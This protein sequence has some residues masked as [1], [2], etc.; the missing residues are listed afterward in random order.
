MEGVKLQPPAG[1]VRPAT[2]TWALQTLYS[3]SAQDMTP[4]ATRSGLI[5]A[6]EATST[7]MRATEKENRSSCKAYFSKAGAH[8]AYVRDEHCC[9]SPPPGTIAA[10]ALLPLYLQTS[11]DDLDHMLSP[12]RSFSFDGRR[13]TTHGPS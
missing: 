1:W 13:Y 2:T 10:K 8:F 5:E 4:C 9:L 12:N 7:A 11:L 6:K 3:P